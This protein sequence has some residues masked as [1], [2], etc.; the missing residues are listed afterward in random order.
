[1][2]V[3]IV[4]RLVAALVAAGMAVY[5][6]TPIMYAMKSNEDVWEG[7]IEFTECVTIRENTYTVFGNLILPLLGVIIIWGFLSAS[8]RQPDEYDV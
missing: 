6:A 3:Q 1:V 4:L 7:C 5:I 2:A 8:R